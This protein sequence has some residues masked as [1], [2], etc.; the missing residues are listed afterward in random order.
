MKPIQIGDMIVHKVLD[1]DHS[2][3]PFDFV[4]PDGDWGVAQAHSDWLAPHHISY[5]SRLVLMSYHSYVIQ[6]GRSNILIE[7]CI[8]NDKKRPLSDTFHMQSSKYLERLA[9][10]ELAPADIDFVMCTHFHPDHVGWNTRLENGI[11]VPTFPNA[12]YV[13]AR[14]EYDHWDAHWEKVKKDPF[15]RASYFDSVLPVVEAGQADF[16]DSDH[17][18]EQGVWL[19]ASY[20]HSP[21]HCMVN[22][23]SG[24]DHGIMTGDVVHHV[25][26]MAAP[27]WVPFFDQGKDKAMATRNKLLDRIVDTPT[28]MFP[29]HFSDTSAGHVRANGDA[30]TFEFVAGV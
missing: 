6:T 8:G 30:Y 29:S 12:R 4:Y 13:F 23:Q 11:W 2:S 5:A 17:E 26:Q 1:K 15:M 19:E 7:T 21:G 24:D 28:L 22:V 27:T 16:V 3:L 14:K 9:A 18:I 10:I 25:M 20:G